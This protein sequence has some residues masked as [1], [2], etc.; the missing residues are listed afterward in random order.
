MGCDILD[1]NIPATRIR[2]Q[3]LK[4]AFLIGY[5]AETR[6]DNLQARTTVNR[7]KL[8]FDQRFYAAQ[9]RVTTRVSHRTPGLGEELV[10]VHGLDHC[11]E[12]HVFVAGIGNIAFCFLIH[13][14]RPL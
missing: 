11:L 13:D 7:L 8:E 12:P 10:S 4:S 14:K 1:L 2:A 9:R 6:F 5:C 3:C